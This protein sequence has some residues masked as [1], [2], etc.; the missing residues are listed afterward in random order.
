MRR[1]TTVFTLTLLLV[2]IAACERQ[3]EAPAPQFAEISL[4]PGFEAQVVFDGTGESRELFIRED[5]D[6][7]VSLSGIRDDDTILGLRDTDGDFVIDVIEP[8]HHITT[9]NEQKVP[10]VHIEYVDD[11]L[12]AIDNSQL[13]RYHLPEGSLTPATA[14][15][16]VAEIPYQSSHRGRTLA[17]DTDGWIY[18]N[19]GA[20]SNAC[21][22]QAKT[23]GSPG[24]DPCPQLEE[25]AGI[26]RWRGDR[27]NQ[28]REAG[29]KFAGGIR[30][31]IAQT[32]D[33][34]YE[35][36]YVG[37]MGRDRLDS[38]WPERFTVQQ[39]AD[40]PAEEFFRVEQG[41][42][43]GWPYCYYD[44][45]EHRKVLAPEYGGDGEIVGRC[46]QYEGPSV[47]FPAHYSP[48]SIAFYHADAF[49]PRYRGGAF[50]ALKG[51]W[52][53]APLPQDGYIVAFVPFED[54]A[55]TGEWEV[56]ADSFK[57][58]ETLFERDNAVHRPQ[59]VFVH[60]D[61]ALYILDNVEGRMWRVTYTG[62]DAVSLPLA[63]EAASDRELLV[64]ASAGRGA[65]LYQQFCAACHQS[66]GGGVPDMFPPLAGSDWVAGDKG[67]LIRTVLHGMQGPI[68]IDGRQY[69]EVMP[70]HGFLSDGDVAALLT[71]VRDRFG[72]G[73]DPVHDSEVTLVRNS[74]DRQAPW[75]ASELETRTGLVPESQPP[76]TIEP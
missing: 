49:P 55:P 6:M 65:E 62:E 60:P 36:L 75:P 9:P 14:A 42:D 70:G 24:L 11:H 12:Y 66:E 20:P 67:R 64:E 41:D 4:P 23:T 59:S 73:A 50:V 32:W 51:S 47:A 74:E 15:E 7:F 71:Y 27:L 58:F 31:A 16:V 8:F 34:V 28:S 19:I 30:N 33:P 25:H 54:G 21:Q 69:D 26:W 56:F 43:F 35:G 44:H 72:N 38:L 3:Q 61:G 68:M 1:E 5:G 22:E 76:G 17:A 46:E 40:L 18:V 57:G 10:R 39:N 37:Q 53:R 48:S 13:V 52:N 2:T 63:P 45:F 29:E